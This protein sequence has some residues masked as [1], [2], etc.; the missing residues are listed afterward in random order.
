MSIRVVW[1]NSEQNILC[2]VIEGKWDVNDLLAAIKEADEMERSVDQPIDF[3]MD[4]SQSAAMPL[5]LLTAA[6]QG[7]RNQP[8][9][10][11]NAI[12]ILVRPGTYIQTMASVAKAIAP[13]ATANIHTANSHPEAVALIE[14]LRRERAGNPEDA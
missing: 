13:N 4:F 9:K 7:E 10:R 3:I 8:V 14:K 2:Y 11:Q 1:A 12:T 5:N 6:R